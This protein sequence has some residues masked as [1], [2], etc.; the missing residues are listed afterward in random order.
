M[1]VLEYASK[2]MELSHFAPTYLVDEK[3]RTNCF[4]VGL[5]PSLKEQMWVRHYTSYEDMYDTA[6]NMEKAIKERNKFY[7][8]QWGLTRE[9]SHPKLLQEVIGVSP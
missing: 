3:L 5:N 9:P 7:N 1:S 4:E 6:I 8:E 2:F